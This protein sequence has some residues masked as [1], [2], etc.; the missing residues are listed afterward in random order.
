ME[1]SRDG[2]FWRENKFLKSGEETREGEIYEEI[3]V[4]LQEFDLERKALRVIPR[5]KQWLAIYRAH[6]V[7]AWTLPGTPGHSRDILKGVWK[8][9]G[10]L[11]E[12]SKFRENL[13]FR[14]HR[15]HIPRYR[16][17]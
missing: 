17:F 11:R 13:N 3:V 16:F 1:S 9:P 6:Q 12:K 5:G 15:K 14:Y 2:D 8:R 7:Y 10:D 4:V